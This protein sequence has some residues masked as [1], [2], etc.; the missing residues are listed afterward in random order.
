MMAAE[1]D[2]PRAFLAALM[3]TGS[4]EAAEGAVSDAITTSGCEENELL[5]A[6]AK[7]ANQLG[8]KCLRGPEIALSLPCELQRLFLVSSVGRKC[9]VLRILMGLTPETISE[10]LNL[11]RDEVDEALCRALID[12][13][14]LAGIHVRACNEAV[15]PEAASAKTGPL[16]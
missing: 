3:F 8:D 15:P 9:F 7:R 1:I 14:R 11:H 10:I 2:V 6:T 12:L 13:P 16:T 5:I 4:A